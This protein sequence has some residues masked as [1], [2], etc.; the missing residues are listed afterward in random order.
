M[1]VP[2]GSLLGSSRDRQEW[3]RSSNWR[4]TGQCSSPA[5]T[6]KVGRSGPTLRSRVD[7]SEI[8]SDVNM[9]GLRS[10]IGTPK[11]QEGGWFWRG[12]NQT[13]QEGQISDPGAPKVPP[14]EGVFWEPQ[15]RP[16]QGRF[17]PPQKTPKNRHFLTI[18]Q[19]ETVGN[20]F[21]YGFALKKSS[22]NGRF[23]GLK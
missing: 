13:L 1:S 20:H 16:L 22:K 3:S 23:L 9:L 17:Y 5:P 14:Q 19:P 7:A 10:H 4:I 11:P 15:N 18:F 6:I 12:Q 8:R 21:S 2:A